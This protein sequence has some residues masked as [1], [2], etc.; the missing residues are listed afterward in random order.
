MLFWER[1][2]FSNNMQARDAFLYSFSYYLKRLV[3]SLKVSRGL[4]RN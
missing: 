3:P 1:W 4:L 2:L